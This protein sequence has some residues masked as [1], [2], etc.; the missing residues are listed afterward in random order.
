M[1]GKK[2]LKK[3]KELLKELQAAVYQRTTLNKKIR[4]LQSEMNAWDRY[5]L[6]EVD[7]DEPDN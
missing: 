7:V 5:L 6:A 2:Y 1:Q 3:R 4:S